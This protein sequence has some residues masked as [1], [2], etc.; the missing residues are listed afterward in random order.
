MH[1]VSYNVV[2]Q[3]NTVIQD[4]RILKTCEIDVPVAADN[5]HGHF[6]SGFWLTND[7][8]AN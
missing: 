6:L 8:F 5:S 4:G 3:N 7:N 1:Q 2:Y